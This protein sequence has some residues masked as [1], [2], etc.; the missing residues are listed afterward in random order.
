MKRSS[1]FVLLTIILAAA[2]VFYYANNS[3]VTD[4]PSVDEYL[5]YRNEELGFSFVYPSDWEVIDFTEITD[6]PFNRV[7]GLKSADTLK[8]I[9]QEKISGNSE[10]NFTLIVSRWDDINKK[11][12][13]VGGGMPSEW[14]HKNLEDYLDN[15]YF[16]KSMTAIDVDGVSA[17]EIMPGGLGT[18]HGVMFERDGLYEILFPKS[19]HRELNEE[20]SQVLDSFKFI[21]SE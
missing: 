4:E 2:G 1:L 19:P 17:Y 9:E 20:E 10:Y 14:S 13:Q 12:S 15:D 8:L 3:K 6:A 16:R 21:E 7:V 18:Y 5:E 11:L